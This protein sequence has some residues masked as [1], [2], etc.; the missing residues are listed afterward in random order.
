M[1]DDQAQLWAEDGHFVIR[2]R[3]GVYDMLCGT[4]KVRLTSDDAE[5][6]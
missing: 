5:A 3:S 6:A 4:E 2:V 1:G